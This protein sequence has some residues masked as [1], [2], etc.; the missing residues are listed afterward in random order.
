MRVSH[1]PR[2]AITSMAASSI[3]VR[4]F[5]VNL[6]LAPITLPHSTSELVNDYLM[7]NDS[8]SAHSSPQETAI[9]DRKELLATANAVCYIEWWFRIYRKLVRGED[10]EGR[11]RGHSHRRGAQRV[12]RWGLSR[13][14]R[15]EDGGARGPSQG[16]RGG[17]DRR[18]LAGGS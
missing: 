4:R 13:P 12:G 2:S 5:C 3:C 18:A 10:D 11:L 9:P 15:V 1:R 16:R 8:T 6:G 7:Y 17:G 14:R